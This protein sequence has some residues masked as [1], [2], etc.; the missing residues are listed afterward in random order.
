[1]FVILSGSYCTKNSNDFPS[2]S[3][4]S[5]PSIIPSGDIAF[6]INDKHHSPYLYTKEEA[7][8]MFQNR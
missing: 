2:S 6:A 3:L 1:L 8:E 4:L 5:I 7:C